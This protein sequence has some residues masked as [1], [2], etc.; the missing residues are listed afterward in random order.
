MINGDMNSEPFLNNCCFNINDMIYN[1]KIKVQ[2]IIKP[3][4]KLCVIFNSRS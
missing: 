1:F 4:N 2:F 3:C